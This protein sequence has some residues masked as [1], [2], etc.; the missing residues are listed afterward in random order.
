MVRFTPYAED[1]LRRR[2]LERDLVERVVTE[3]EQVVDEDGRKVGQSRY[4]DEVKNKEYLLRVVYEET[5]EDKLVVT[6]YR[7]S[8]I[9]KYWRP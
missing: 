3:P 2:R 5:G 9:R 8:K 6:I 7:T 1:R 4:R